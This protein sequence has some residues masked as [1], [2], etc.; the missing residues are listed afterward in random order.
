MNV[1]EILEERQKTHGS[2]GDH[3]EITQ[4]LKHLAFEAGCGAT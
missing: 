1:E 4:G 3:A 2:F